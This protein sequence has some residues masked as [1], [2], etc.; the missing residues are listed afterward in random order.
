[1]AGDEFSIAT[2]RDN[3]DR[4]GRT[5][6]DV[7]VIGG[8]V[9]GVGAARDAALRGW[10]TA[11]VER[12]DFA[13]GTSSR[14]G[15]M[16]HGGL[17]YLAEGHLRLVAEGLA[18]RAVLR[19]VAPHL[20]AP[21]Q[22]MIPIY[23]S[24]L[25]IA[26]MGVGVAL[27]QGLAL[28]RAAG[29]AR[30]VGR[31]G[32]VGLEPMV[33]S[34]RLAGAATY[35]DC[36]TDDARLVLALIRDAHRHGA[37]VANHA[38]A[39]ALLTSGDRVVGAAVRDALTG[40]TCEARA[41]AVINAAGPW[42]GRVAA[43]GGGRALRLRPTMGSHIVV[44]R[45]RLTIRRAIIV[46]S[47]R[48]R[49]HLYLIPWGHTVI[50][51]TTETD[52]AGDPEEAY[53]TAQDV[54]YLLEAIQA[55]F[56]RAGLGP[57]DII[58]T[59]AGVRPLLDH[60][61]LAAYHLPRDYQAVE[62][63]PG[64]ISIAGGKLTTFRRMA[65]AAVDLAARAIGGGAAARSRSRTATA[66]LDPRDGPPD[67]DLKG[68]VMQAAKHEMAVTLC[69]CLIRRLHLMHEL[70]DQ[71]LAAAA[72][73]ARIMAPVQGWTE[74]QAQAEIACY[75]AAVA[76]TRRWQTSAGQPDADGR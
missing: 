9:T 68:R 69:D 50:I 39:V 6:W 22:F 18:E 23:G 34:D 73:A 52:Y 48:D 37:T 44:P 54:A 32:A 20:V 70:P 10:K 46:S 60:P 4:L 63:P 25:R 72:P 14:T 49:R 28:G 21:Q 55:A 30:V 62:D 56:P 74:A 64:L 58:S 61:G 38:P 1:M 2:R 40:R 57:R 24:P 43:M 13:S 45:S 75:E 33:A 29:P 42:V 16:V 71:G 15:R 11:L 59:F 66:P 47:P 27:Y 36:L 8:G 19:R 41:R 12:E 65:Q 17:R 67:G 35:Y 7:L 76:H 53:A 51:G 26:K 31:R 3:L 5:T